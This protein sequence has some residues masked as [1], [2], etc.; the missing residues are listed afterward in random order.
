MNMPPDFK[1]EWD[2][3]RD[4]IIGLGEH[5][6]RKSYYPE[7]QQKLRELEQ[8]KSTLADANRQMQ[9]VLDAASEISI[10]ATDQN[11]LITTFNK[12]AEKLLGYT[13]EEVV[14]LHTPLLF[15]SE[16][17]IKE[18]VIEIKNRY[19]KDLEGFNAIVEGAIRSGAETLETTYICKDGTQLLVSLT[20]TVI[21]SQTGKI[22]GFLG[23]ATNIT[24]HKALEARLLQSQKMESVGQLAGGLA[25]DFN[26]VLTIITGY[27]SLLHARLNQNADDA[28]MVKKILAAA[29]KAADL[30]SSLLTFS[31]KQVSTKK[32][33]DL[34]HIISNIG[35]S[36]L[37]LIGED[38]QLGI[39]ISDNPLPV[40][41]DKGQ[42]EQVMLNM[43]TNARDA[44]PHGG[45]LSIR[46]TCQQIDDQFVQR[47]GYCVPGKYA[48]ITISDSGRGM[49]S[50]TRTKIFE[51]FFTTKES[52]KGTGLG[53][54][55]VYGI[56]NQHNGHINV[57]SEIGIGTTFQIYLPIIE[58]ETVT[59]T[60][61][62]D[63]DNQQVS[64]GDE[65][66]LVAE[67]DPVVRML[68]ETILK[69]SGY[70]LILAENGQ[71]AVDKY[72]A[73]RSTIKL[74]ILDMIMPIKSG[75]HAYEEIR[76]LQPDIKALFYSG[77]AP[78]I[79]QRQGSLEGEY[80]L[81]MKPVKP[82]ELLCQIRKLLDS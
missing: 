27:A 60:T 64:G 30:T 28:N 58:T 72:I 2:S 79:I 33:H 23:I 29:Q 19:N 42:I 67:D 57:Y 59:D 82:T 35:E 63:V 61:G 73:N 69:E 39:S 10:I 53:L 21:K 54:S 55:M 45:L 41:V 15:H 38:V 77:Y 31:R 22:T 46:T 78:D 9:S 65:T 20:I 14:G 43:S 3:K 74:I 75:K 80:T 34:N 52:G 32:C 68:I 44:M 13:A 16:N 70:N 12:G 8:T 18:T 26:N 51:P 25:H 56:V 50:E 40:L 48:L 6:A 71:D 7:L 47:H 36:L 1:D 76:Q 17:E 11:G 62:L 81:M 24:E 49:D 37:K 5:S 4:Q 66:I